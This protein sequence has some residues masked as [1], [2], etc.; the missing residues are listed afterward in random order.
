MLRAGGQPIHAVYITLDTEDAVLR[1]DVRAAKTKR[2]VN[3]RFIR[4]VHRSV[5]NVV[6][7]AIK[8]GL[9]DDFV[10]YDNNVPKGTQPIKVAT[11]V[12]SKI[13]VH[14]PKLWDKFVLKGKY[15]YGGRSAGK[16]WENKQ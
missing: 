10:L 9:F 13:T 1:S 16:Y 7:E 2:F 3:H 6:P 8:R 11:A 12:G 5:S 14:N 15:S 4:D